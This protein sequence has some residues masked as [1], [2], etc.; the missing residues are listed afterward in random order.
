MSTYLRSGEPQSSTTD[1][2]KM[3]KLDV[4]KFTRTLYIENE[5]CTRCTKS[6]V[7]LLFESQ[8]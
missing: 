1:E 5:N 4:A 8:T 2:N 6:G 3:V 7:C